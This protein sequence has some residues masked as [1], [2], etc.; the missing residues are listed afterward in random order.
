[1]SPARRLRF[2]G[3]T[4]DPTAWNI[5][6]GRG[7]GVETYTRDPANVTVKAGE[8]RITAQ[9][10]DAEAFRSARVTTRGR[11]PV[12]PGSYVE[13]RML[14]PTRPG[15]WPAFYTVGANEPDVRWPACGELDVAEVIGA[16]PHLARRNLHGAD[17]AG[18]HVSY[19]WDRVAVD[20]GCGLGYEWHTYGVAFGA[21]A[22]RFDVDRAHAATI[23]RADAGAMVWPFDQPQHLMFALS[24]GKAA[25]DPGP[26]VWPQTMRV[27]RVDVW[28]TPPAVT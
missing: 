22:V 3:H 4:L 18:R 25:G 1:V 14:T 19:G 24:V 21:D 2:T 11:T 27:S 17:A 12:P 20:V 15:C 23:T 5:E 13:A 6:P 7:G 9:R 10:D 16:T 26:G 28:D 8:L